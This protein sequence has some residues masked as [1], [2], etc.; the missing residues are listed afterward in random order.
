MQN[1]TYLGLC[2]AHDRHLVKPSSFLPLTT[3]SVIHLATGWLF[4]LLRLADHPSGGGGQAI[5][6]TQSGLHPTLPFVDG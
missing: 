3:E 4:S 2:P 6:M 1:V 5:T